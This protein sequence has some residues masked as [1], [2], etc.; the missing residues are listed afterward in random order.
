MFC[1]HAESKFAEQIKNITIEE[2]KSTENWMNAE[3]AIL[4]AGR[5]SHY[6]PAELDDEARDALLASM[7]ETDAPVDRFRAVNE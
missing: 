1:L 2:L 6:A 3:P 5:M 7:A 4:K